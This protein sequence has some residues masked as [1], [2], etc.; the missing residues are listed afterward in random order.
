[1]KFYLVEGYHGGVTAMG[2]WGN[3]GYSQAPMWEFDHAVPTWLRDHVFRRLDSF[4]NYIVGLELEAITFEHWEKTNPRLIR[5]IVERVRKGQLEILDGTY[6][7]PYGHILSHEAIVRQFLYGQEVL[8]RILGTKSL[9]H[10]KQEHM[11]LPNMPGLLLE[12]GIKYA[13]L[14]SHIHH[15]GCC[16]A[17]DREFI[18]WQGP[19]GESIPAVP[20]W[21]MDHYPY[22]YSEETVEKFEATA[23]E[24]GIDRMLLS[25]GLDVCH[26]QD[27][28]AEYAEQWQK[29]VDPASA[30]GHLCHEKFC[31]AEWPTLGISDAT[32]EKLLQRGYEPISIAEFIDG[33]RTDGEARTFDA[34]YFH[35]SFLWG[36]RGDCVLVAIKSAEASLYA[37]EVAQSLLSRIGGEGYPDEDQA[38]EWAWKK[39]LEAQNHD[40]HVAPGSFS[41]ST[42]GFLPRMAEQWCRDAGQEAE[43]VLRRDTRDLVGHLATPAPQPHVVL[44]NPLSF[45]RSDPAEITIELPKGFAR[46]FRLHC[47][48][49][50]VPFD[51]LRFGRFSDGT[52]SRAEVVLAGDVPGFGFQAIAVEPAEDLPEMVRASTREVDTGAIEATVTE[53]GTLAMLKLS[54]DGMEYV[55]TERFDG[56]ELA[57][58][59]GGGPV[60]TGQGAGELT[61]VRG[62]YLTQFQARTTLGDKPVVTQLR[63]YAGCSRI[64]FETEIDFS[65]ETATAQSGYIFEFDP[66]GA[67]RAHFDPAFDGEFFSDLALS[68]EKSARK[69]TPGVSFG[70]M[71]DRQRGLTL[72]NSGNMGYYRDQD[73]GGRLSLILAAGTESFWYGPYFLSEK[74]RFRYAVLPHQG[75]WAAARAPL[76]AAEFN[77]PIRAVTVPGNLPD[78]TRRSLLNISEETVMATALVQRGGRTFLRLWNSSPQEVSATVDCLF[79]LGD[80]AVTDIFGGNPR[81]LPV[82]NGAVTLT[83]P[84]FAMRTL[85]LDKKS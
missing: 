60:R 4:P 5:E 81:P 68:V 44:F 53:N 85:L 67:V 17:I 41:L 8:Q 30:A 6:T 73:G 25:H 56:N 79:P 75:D 28:I 52:L 21:F 31:L 70:C 54:A 47:D 39:V 1:M 80:V 46:G 59:F 10:Y 12:A 77:T 49:N 55:S 63:F 20:N 11:F 14:R 19:D 72:I 42:G 18:L 38:L 35:Y 57:A 26:D 45:H 83:F 51:C 65:F 48:G 82:A 36:T 15:M 76:R 40:I 69:I 37:A 32:L 2:R 62:R 7:Q 71:T 84:P 3:K 23:K 78:P 24:R 27:Y 61:C 9:T 13:V 29:T 66:F 16:P 22:S 33:Y 74:I 58:D 64:D 43:G 50:E 34:D